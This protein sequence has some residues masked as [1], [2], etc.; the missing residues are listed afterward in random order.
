[1]RAEYEKIARNVCNLTNWKVAPLP[2]RQGA[3]GVACVLAYLLGAKPAPLDLANHIGVPQADVE[4][5]FK[6]LNTNGYFSSKLDA[7]N[8]VMFAREPEVFS[9]GVKDKQVYTKE[10]VYLGV[11][12]AK[13]Q[14]QNAWAIIAGIAGGLTGLRETLTPAE[15]A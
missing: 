2:E 7:R 14:A 13:D 1:M 15:T 4:L 10:G 9:A 6:R 12:S 11:F 5:P 8:D 3:I